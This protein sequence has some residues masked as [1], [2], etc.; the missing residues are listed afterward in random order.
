MKERSIGGM[1]TVAAV[2]IFSRSEVKREA[3]YAYKYILGE[4]TLQP[5]KQWCTESD[6]VEDKQLECVGHIQYRMG[7]RLKNY[8]LRN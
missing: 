2:S 8:K 7:T 5:T 1:E 3:K 4:G 6:G